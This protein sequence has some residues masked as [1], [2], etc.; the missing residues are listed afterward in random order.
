MD[1]NTCRDRGCCK[2][3]E[4]IALMPK[5]LREAFLKSECSG[6][7]RDPEADKP[8]KEIFL[9]RLQESK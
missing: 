6:Y 2:E 8:L 3:K 9:R 5:D 7:V 1:C 4:Q